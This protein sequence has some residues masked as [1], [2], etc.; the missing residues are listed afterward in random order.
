M[1]AGLRQR[2]FA[3]EPG[4]VRG[5][6][7]EYCNYQTARLVGYGD[8]AGVHSDVVGCFEVVRLPITALFLGCE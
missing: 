1:L 2:S 5:V 8:D 6:I 3:S 4:W 7:T